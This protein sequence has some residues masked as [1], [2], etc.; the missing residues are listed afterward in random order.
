M[1]YKQTAMKFPKLK[2]RG[3][4][5]L[6]LDPGSSNM[7]IAVSE[8]ANGKLY[9]LCNSV[10]E[11]PIKELKGDIQSSRAKFMA[12]ID[13][14]VTHFDCKAII[15]ERF[16]TRGLMGKTIESVSLMLGCLLQGYPHLKVKLIPAS[17]WKNDF[18]RTVGAG[19]K[20]LLKQLYKI[21]GTEPHQLDAMLIG[22]Y[23]LQLAFKTPV[24][25]SLEYLIDCANDG[26]LIDLHKRKMTLGDL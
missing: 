12:E 5:I 4:A 24:Q 26:S 14:W 16:Q 18:T 11:S 20:E 6:S 17:Q 13:Q 25:Y 1:M 8:F 15:A 9:H 19:D 22:W 10:M 2:R 23:G 7:G 3:T 21:V